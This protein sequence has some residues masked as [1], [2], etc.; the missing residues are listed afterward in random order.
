MDAQ[1]TKLE[2]GIN[3]PVANDTSQGDLLGV[4]P[5]Q[6]PRQQFNVVLDSRQETQETVEAH[7]QATNSLLGPV[8]TL[9]LAGLVAA[10]LVRHLFDG[11]RDG[12]KS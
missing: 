9:L 5:K 3:A 4:I 2:P 7:Q 8:G 10:V 11:A 6:D 12:S 1:N